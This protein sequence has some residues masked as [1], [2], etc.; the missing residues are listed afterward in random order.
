MGLQ[1]QQF[2]TFS[3]QQP[4]HGNPGPAG[5]KISDVTGFHLLPEQGRAG[6]LSLRQRNL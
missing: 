2:A 6:R 1:R 3:G 5:H 4:L